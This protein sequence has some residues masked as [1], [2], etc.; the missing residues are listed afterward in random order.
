[1]SRCEAHDLRDCDECGPSWR[2]DYDMLS[3]AIDALRLV[4]NWSTAAVNDRNITIETRLEDCRITAQAALDRIEKR[5]EED[6]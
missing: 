5:L 6:R 4:V 3:D 1:M 2:S